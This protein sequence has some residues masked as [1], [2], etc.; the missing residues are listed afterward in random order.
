MTLTLKPEED[1]TKK[2]HYRLSPLQILMWKSSTNYWQTKSNSI[3]RRLYA[4]TYGVDP[5]N[6]KIRISI[7]VILI[8]HI[9]R[10]KKQTTQSYQLTPK[11]HLTISKA[12]AL[13]SSALAW[14]IPWMEEPGVLL[15]M[16]SLRV[17]HDW[18]TSLSLSTF[19]HWRRK[20]QT[21]PVFL[22]GVSQGQG[23]VSWWAS[24]MGCRLWGHTESETT[25]VT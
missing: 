2:W 18:V 22:P 10:I 8:Q 11:K 24:L 25:E 16:G 7:Y 12:M 17:G 9:N 5:R 14:K 13:H 19:M 3:S 4:M 21:T 15:S 23:M 6:A 1:T 20:W